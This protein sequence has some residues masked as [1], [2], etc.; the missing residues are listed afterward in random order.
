M[1]FKTFGFLVAI[2]GAAFSITLCGIGIGIYMVGVLLQF[3]VGKDYDWR[4]YPQAVFLIPLIA[5][6]LVSLFISDYFFI[7]LRG[8]GKYLQGFILLY[9]GLDVI[10]SPREVRWVVSAFI[11]AYLVAGLAGLCQDILG[12]DFIYFREAIPYYGEMLRITG[13]FKHSNDYATFLI[14]GFVITG[15]FLYEDLRNRKIAKAVLWTVLISL[16][17]YVMVRS[18][19][20]SALVSL[21]VALIAF[22]MF[23]KYRWIA[24]LAV[25]SALG[26][27]WFVPSALGARLRELVDLTA[28]NMPE[29]LLLLETTSKMIRQS[30]F[31]GLGLNTYSDYFPQFKPEH[32]EP[33]MYAHN[34][35]F[36]MAAESGLLGILFYVLLILAFVFWFGKTAA[37]SS[38]SFNRTLQ[39]GVLSG[40]IGIL[41]NAAFESVFQSTQL[42]TLFWVLMGVATA[43]AY[44]TFFE[45]AG[46]KAS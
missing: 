7:S 34:S 2:A 18:M 42:R 32:Y 15:A 22:S 19:S 27:F 3:F 9:A 37:V 4:P 46:E 36:Q 14:P 16:L 26:V 40:I 13:P 20:R 39:V 11:G 8:F 30:P 43:L 33:I 25:A 28:G 1:N 41:V 31:F 35:Y 38:P 24:S 23:F 5:T 45:R 29:R 17:A 10:R 44:N 6:L 21:I 12:V